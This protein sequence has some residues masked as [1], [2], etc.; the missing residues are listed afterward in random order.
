MSQFQGFG[1]LFHLTRTIRDVTLCLASLGINVGSYICFK[2]EEFHTYFVSLLRKGWMNAYMKLLRFSA[3]NKA[4]NHCT[5]RN[6]QHSI[7]NDE[8]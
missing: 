1:G 5:K 3:T 6:L 7:I 8:Q 4:K 2:F